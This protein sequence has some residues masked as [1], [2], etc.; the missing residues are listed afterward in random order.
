MK[1]ID[2]NEEQ[3][4][5]AE[6]FVMNSAIKGWSGDVVLIRKRDILRLMAWYGAVRAESG[7][8]SKLGPIECHGDGVPS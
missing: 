4:K 6:E 5:H 3:I 8:G 2:V 7:N 1:G